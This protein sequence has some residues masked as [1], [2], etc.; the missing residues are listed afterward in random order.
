M[1]TPGDKPGVRWS[2]RKTG[3][4]AGGKEDDRGPSKA[5]ETGGGLDLGEDDRS[6]ATCLSPARGGSM[7]SM[8][9]IPRFH[10]LTGFGTAVKILRPDAL[11]QE[12][13]VGTSSN[14]FT[15]IFT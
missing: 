7:L 11:N 13:V 9:I 8:P 5:G 15:Q 4:A 14:F 6:G 10:D 1:G 2:P 3:L 12:M